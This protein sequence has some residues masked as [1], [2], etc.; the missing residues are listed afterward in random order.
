VRP[1]DW[2]FLGALTGSHTVV[3]KAIVCSTYQS[4]TNPPGVEIPIL[5]GDVQFDA[6]ADVRGTLDLTTSGE[7]RWPRFANDL[8]APYGNE[9]FITRGIDYSNGTTVLVSQ[10]YFRI[11]GVEQDEPPDGPIRISARDRMSGIVDA[12]LE[13]PLQFTAG[14]TYGQVVD[15]L[16]FAVYPDAFIEWDSGTDYSRLLGR[17][18][19]AEEDRYGFINDLMT[20]LGKIWYWDYRGYLVV[21]SPPNPG[22]PVWTVAAGKDGVLVSMGRELGREGVYNTVVATG[23]AGDS[24]PPTRAVARDDNPDSPTYWLGRFGP[25]PKFFSS[26]LLTSNAQ[27]ATAARVQLSRSIGLPYNV[28][29]QSVANPAIEPW[30]PVR[31]TYPE[32]V[33]SLNMQSEIH[34]IE[35]L[36]LGLTY[37]DTT[38]A[39][40]REKTLVLI[41]TEEGL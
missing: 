9:V 36:K 14:Q 8:L 13:R 39:K 10:G 7:G 34:V 6:N 24:T 2:K 28:E 22:N 20:A 30:D 19:V 27:A 41:S 18:V 12:R 29:F 17:V 4:G 3:S 5:A 1:V 40:T 15:Q 31:I 26:P 37:A 23:E 25:V 21:K 11:Y 38:S 32:R 16:V 35:Q 33:R